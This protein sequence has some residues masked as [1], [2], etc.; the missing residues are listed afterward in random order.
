MNK[1][2]F[3]AIALFALALF[4]VALGH[5]MFGHWCDTAADHCDSRES[6]LLCHAMAALWISLPFLL[7]AFDIPRFFRMSDSDHHRHAPDSF[8]IRG[9]SPPLSAVTA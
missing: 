6:C 3:R 7:T 9:R 4:F 5:E 8:Q 1:V 2:T